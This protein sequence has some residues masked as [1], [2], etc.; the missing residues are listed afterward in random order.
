[1]SYPQKAS[2]FVPGAGTVGIHWDTVIPSFYEKKIRKIP[3]KNIPIGEIRFFGEHL[4]AFQKCLWIT[5]EFHFIL[6]AIFGVFR[7]LQCYRTV[8]RYGKKTGIK[9]FRIFNIK[10]FYIAPFGER[11]RAN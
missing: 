7:L 1:M 11:G 8:T 9:R 5:R 4:F 3:V 2:P 6:M 10:Y